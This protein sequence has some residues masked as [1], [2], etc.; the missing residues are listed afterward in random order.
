[1]AAPGAGGL[2]ACVGS[3]TLGATPDAMQNSVTW[4]SAALVVSLSLDGTL[5]YLTVA[6]GGALEL[7]RR[8]TGHQAP[9][10]ALH[11][12]RA[13][14]AVLTGDQAG[15]VCVWRPRDEGRSVFDA[16]VATG[17]A[18]PKKVSCV[19]VGGGG[20]AVG[21]WDDKLRVGDAASGAFTGVV[22]LPGQP[23][24]V[25]VAP[26]APDVRVVVTGGA[27]LVVAGSAVVQTVDAPW[28]PTCVSIAAGGS[29][30]VAV[31]GADKRVH[32]FALA[33]GGGPGCLT[34]GAVTPEAAAAVSAVAVSPDGARVALGDAGR[35]VRL[36]AAGD[37]APLVS[38][39]W[40]AHTTRVTGLAW[41]PSGAL[42][43]SVSSDRRICLWEPGSDAVRKT[44]DLAHPHPFVGVDW[45][46]ED[47]LL[48]AGADGVV[49]RRA[50]VL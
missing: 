2:Y 7:A 27:V 21:S 50:L 35:E 23:K 14:G 47:V 29:G 1:M 40:M 26:G 39:R 32:L 36:Y 5:N 11:V 6:P 41:S 25:A 13:T 4:P 34:A 15:R 3:V 22:A 48:T 43:A 12:D 49:V 30:V 18:P 17:D 24:G 31:G 45:L 37:G 20:M 33:P 19:A 28:A 9:V 16:T 38:G 10:C 8:V 46:A 42:L 44:F